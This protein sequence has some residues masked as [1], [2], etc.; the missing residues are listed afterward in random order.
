[1]KITK[2]QLKQ[3]IKE[4]LSRVLD[5]GKIED[6]E[7]I[8]QHI[9]FHLSGW[10]SIM[11]S[12]ISGYL[13]RKNAPKI[14]KSLADDLRDGVAGKEMPIS[15]YP[16]DF[17]YVLSHISP[18]KQEQYKGLMLGLAD[19][20]EGEP[21]LAHG[22]KIGKRGNWYAA[23]TGTWDASRDWTPTPYDDPQM[24]HDY[25]WEDMEGVS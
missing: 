21:E 10:F 24:Q 4:E 22:R 18:D 2:N 14:A 25:G 23:A 19:A 3:I 7:K 5:E 6:D 13:K 9:A 16:V 17:G 11:A 1:M 12:R 15:R 20:I 8:K